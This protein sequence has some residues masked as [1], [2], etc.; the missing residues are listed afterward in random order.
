M[1]IFIIDVISHPLDGKTYLV[2][3][4]LEG[5]ND[6]SSIFAKLQTLASEKDTPARKNDLELSLGSGQEQSPGHLDSKTSLNISNKR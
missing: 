5:K 3:S 1:E 4:K 2:F 6:A